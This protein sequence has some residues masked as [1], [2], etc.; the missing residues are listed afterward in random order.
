MTQFCSLYCKSA[1]QRTLISNSLQMPN[2]EPLELEALASTLQARR[3]S[4]VQETDTGTETET[5]PLQRS[6]AVPIPIRGRAGAPPAELIAEQRPIGGDLI[7]GKLVAEP[8]DSVGLSQVTSPERDELDLSLEMDLDMELDLELEPELMAL[9]ENLDPLSQPDSFSPFSSSDVSSHWSSSTVSPVPVHVPVKCTA[10]PPKLKVKP[11]ALGTGSGKGSARA[12]ATTCPSPTPPRLH[13][14]PSNP[15]GQHEPAAGEEAQEDAGTAEKCRQ[16]E[17]HGSRAQGQKQEQGEGESE[18]KS[19][20]KKKTKPMQSAE[21]TAKTNPSSQ[22]KPKKY[23]IMNIQAKPINLS[24]KTNQQFMKEKMSKQQNVK[25]RQDQ[26]LE[27][28]IDLDTDCELGME[29]L[30]Q[31]WAKAS[32]RDSQGNR[33]DRNPSEKRSSETDTTDT[34]DTVDPADT[35]DTADTRDTTDSSS[36]SDEATLEEKSSSETLVLKTKRF[37]CTLGSDNTRTEKRSTDGGN[38]D[39]KISSSNGGKNATG[40]ATREGYGCL[41]GAMP[42]D[43][44]VNRNRS[45]AIYAALNMTPPSSDDSNQAPSSDPSPALATGSPLDSSL[46]LPRHSFVGC[47]W[48]AT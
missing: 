36:N 37:N 45:T 43:L 27:P 18:S 38:Q 22:A 4:Q 23:Y 25:R 47:K 1:L 41:S 35:T 9:A 19:K 15:G 33:N 24:S 28:F 6:R 29:H 10:S 11:V 13:C 32:R 34:T 3:A 2:D 21:K 14:V 20:S 8:E 31:Y 40:A 17:R 12:R 48:P 30:E 5:I 39:S 26:D 42:Y 7:G 44:S 46:G 16:E